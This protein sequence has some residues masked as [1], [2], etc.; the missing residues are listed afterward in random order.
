MNNPF[1]GRTPSLSDPAR[2]VIAVTPSDTADLPSVGVAF[3]AVTAGD[4]AFVAPSGETRTIPVADFMIMPVGVSKI[5]E[6]GTTATGI[7]VFMV[8]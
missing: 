7:H 5:L 1:A 3:Y 6:T 4:V 8:A 2:D